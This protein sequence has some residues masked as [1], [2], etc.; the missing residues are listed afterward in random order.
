MVHIIRFACGN[1]VYKFHVVIFAV[2][3]LVQNLVLRGLFPLLKKFNTKQQNKDIVRMY[4]GFLTIGTV[5][6][7]Y[8]ISNDYL[9][10]NYSC[11]CIIN[12]E[13]GG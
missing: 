5:K 1:R 12:Y 2:H 10:S 8:I 3:V 7:T 6:Y 9:V 11:D 4:I 13:V